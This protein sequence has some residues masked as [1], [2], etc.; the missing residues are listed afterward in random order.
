LA[1]SPFISPPASLIPLQEW[2]QAEL[3]SVSPQGLPLWVPDE[4]WQL[5]VG[6][7]PEE[8]L[9]KLKKLKN[10]SIECSPR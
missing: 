3:E 1:A 6:M 10:Q 4:A 8:K 9:K 5:H 2:H 7:A